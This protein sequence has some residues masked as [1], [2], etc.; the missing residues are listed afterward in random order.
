[1]FNHSPPP[2]VSGARSGAKSGVSTVERN[3]RYLPKSAQGRHEMMAASAA[4]RLAQRTLSEQRCW[5][6]EIVDLTALISTSDC[7]GL[8]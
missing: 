8:A 5:I 6:V 4:R 3:T 1:M 7:T 2:P